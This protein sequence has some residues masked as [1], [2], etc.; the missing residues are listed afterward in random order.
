MTM[1]KHGKTKWIVLL[2][3]AV[4]LG[5]LLIGATVSG[6]FDRLDVD[7]EVSVILAIFS[8]LVLVLFGAL[9]CVVLFAKIDTQVPLADASSVSEPFPHN[10]GRFCMLAEI[11]RKKESYVGKKY[12]AEGLTL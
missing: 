9:L 6:A 5:G 12:E 4:L 10:D 1:N 2:S 8:L 11:D 7:R 3:V